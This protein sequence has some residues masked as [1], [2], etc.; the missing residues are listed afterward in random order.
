MPARR[1]GRWGE[2]AGAAG[3]GIVGLFAVPRKVAIRLA[4]LVR[5]AATPVSV[6]PSGIVMVDS[7]A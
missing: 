6:E 7:E 5:M 3:P 4:M 2:R 1:V